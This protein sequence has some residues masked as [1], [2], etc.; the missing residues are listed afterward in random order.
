MHF[1]H[2]ATLIAD[3][4]TVNLGVWWQNL[5]EGY[6]NPY[7]FGCATKLQGI[8]ASRATRLQRRGATRLHAL[9]VD[10]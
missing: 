2:G 8:T 5:F 6:L 3:F 9:T 1:R 10:N 7:L 4:H